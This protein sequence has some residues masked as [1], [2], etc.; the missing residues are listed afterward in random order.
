[1]RINVLVIVAVGLA[2]GFVAALPATISE[3]KP[4]RPI[5]VEGGESDEHEDPRERVC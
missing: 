1:M 2:S 3:T 5:S 4:S